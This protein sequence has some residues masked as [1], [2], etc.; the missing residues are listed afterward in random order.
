MRAPRHQRR[1]AAPIAN[2]GPTLNLKLDC[3]L[4]GRAAELIEL[5]LQERLY[6][7]DTAPRTLHVLL[8]STNF[9]V[10]D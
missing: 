8:R 10:I 3:G 7:G 1:P 6:F 5:A 2:A 4:P 9:L